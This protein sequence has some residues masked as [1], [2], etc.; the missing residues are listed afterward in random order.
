[1]CSRP[2]PRR[3]TCSSAASPTPSPSP[4]ARSACSAS[5][6]VVTYHIDTPLYVT[7]FVWVLNRTRSP[8]CR[9][10]RRKVIDD[11]CTTSGP[12]RWSALEP[13]SRPPGAPNRQHHR[14]RDGQAAP[15]E[16]L[17]A[18]RKAVAPLPPVAEE[19]E[20]GRRR[21]QA[22][23]RRAAEPREVQSPPCDASGDADL[24]PAH[25]GGPDH[26]IRSSAAA[27]FVGI[28]AADIFLSVFLRRVLRHL[29]SRQL[30]LTACC[31]AC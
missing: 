29:D 31:W 9:R 12:R 16:Q 14:A 23:A 18:W 21:S 24:P 3:A 19:R 26:V 17:D 2:R 8:R 20:E 5:T 25:A 1:M 10:R 22:G 13:T 30:R 6:K 28:V 11:H 7:P 4:G 15:P 27:S